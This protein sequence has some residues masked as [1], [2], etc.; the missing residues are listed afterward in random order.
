[1]VVDFDLPPKLG[2]C[3]VELLLDRAD[4]FSSAPRQLNLTL[5]L[6]YAD[7]TG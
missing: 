5:Q 1:M 3:R 4:T 7:S 6:L 2:Y